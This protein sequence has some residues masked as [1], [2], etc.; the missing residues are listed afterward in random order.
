MEKNKVITILTIAVF[1]MSAFAL[2][3]L[4]AMCDNKLH[5]HLPE[6]FYYPTSYGNVPM[7]KEVN[8]V[9]RD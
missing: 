8:D 6:T 2:M 7:C 1:L 3:W 4:H 9:A 5:Q